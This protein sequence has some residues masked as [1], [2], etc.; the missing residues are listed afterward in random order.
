MFLPLCGLAA[1]GGFACQHEVEQEKPNIIFIFADDMGYGDVSALNENS[2]IQTEN[3]DRIAGEG[4]VFTDAHASSSV[5]TPSRYGLL[6][7]RYN[8]RSDIKEAYCGETANL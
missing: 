4:V 8:W 2:K 6:T 3:I 5:S 1:F 7:G